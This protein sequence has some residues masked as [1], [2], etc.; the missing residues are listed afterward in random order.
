MDGDL[1]DVGPVA[2]QIPRAVEIAGFGGSAPSGGE[3]P[4]TLLPPISG[5]FSHCRLLDLA[6]AERS[7]TQVHER[8]SDVVGGRCFGFSVQELVA[9]SLQ[10]SPHGQFTVLE[11]EVIPQQAKYFTFAQAQCQHEGVAGIEGVVIGS[12]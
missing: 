4:A 8:E 7:S 12:G 2:A 5:S 9:D 10:L 1:A 3:H 11:I 6:V